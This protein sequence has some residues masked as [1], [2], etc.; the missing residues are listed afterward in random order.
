MKLE[1][2]NIR[3]MSY[4]EARDILINAYNNGLLCV[5]GGHFGEDKIYDCIQALCLALMALD[6]L[7]DN[8]VE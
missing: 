5:C 4:G 1:D 3:K 2:R 8:Y 7:K 6:E